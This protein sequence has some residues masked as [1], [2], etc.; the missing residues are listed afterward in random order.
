MNNCETKLVPFMGSDLMAS[1]DNN[2][3]V[4]VGVRWV[5]GGIGL[6]KNQ[7]DRQIKN[8]QDDSVLSKGAS[9]LTLPT[10]GGLQSAL[11]LQLD[12]VPLWLAKISITPT[13]ERETPEVAERLIQYQL[14]AKDVLAAAFLPGPSAQQTRA[15]T[16]KQK[17]RLSILSN[18]MKAKTA[19]DK[20][21][22]I[23][24]A[25]DA[26]YGSETIDLVEKSIMESLAAPSAPSTPRAPRRPAT[27]R[28][29]E[30]EQ[31]FRDFAALLAKAGER[32]KIFGKDYILIPSKE[33]RKLADDKAVSYVAFLGWAKKCGMLEA[34]AQGKGVKTTYF[35]GQP[36]SCVRLITAATPEQA[37]IDAEFEEV[38]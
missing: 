28:P 5:C 26:G 25:R 6:N 12:Y 13:M 17:E 15:E 19:P 16:A 35:H 32:K 7:I 11:C 2:G 21:F 38:Q 1:K 8:I 14:K 37:V 9:N 34:N 23:A 10:N 31:E 20:L 3:Q 36:V 27:N 30:S 33:A 24:L 22:A 18:Y 4:W 29:G